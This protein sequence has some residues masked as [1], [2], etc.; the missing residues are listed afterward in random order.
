MKNDDGTRILRVVNRPAQVRQQA[1]SLAWKSYIHVEPAP[2]KPI[3]PTS[4][5]AAF[6]NHVRIGGRR[7]SFNDAASM[8]ILSALIFAA[9]VPSSG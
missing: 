5:H 2:L 3:L 4:S 1:K 7:L 6:R 8:R 9:S